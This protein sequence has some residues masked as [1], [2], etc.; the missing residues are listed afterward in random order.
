MVMNGECVFP[1]VKYLLLLLLLIMML[2][3]LLL[4][5][6]IWPA[7][8]LEPLDGCLLQMLVGDTVDAPTEHWLTLLGKV[9]F[10]S[11]AFF[12]LV[13]QG[14]KVQGWLGDVR[15]GK[16]LLVGGFLHVPH[17]FF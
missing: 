12:S 6:S 13:G 4:L 11:M 10:F 16:G 3:L 15:A 8:L 9:D 17:T 2:L 1:N 5:L 7:A 14:V